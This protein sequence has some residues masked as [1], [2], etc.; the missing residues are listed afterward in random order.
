MDLYDRLNVPRSAGKA[1]I[2]AHY[3]REAKKH[4]PDM[5]PDDPD[6]ATTNMQEI[7]H[8]YAV[9]KDPE[10]RAQYDRTDES[11]TQASQNPAEAILAALMSMLTRKAI[12]E[13]FNIVAEARKKLQEAINA[14]TQA[15]PVCLNAISALEKI[16]AR[17][18]VTGDD[19][20][21]AMAAESHIAKAKHELEAKTASAK[22]SKDAL[23]MLEGYTDS[24]I[25]RAMAPEQVLREQMQGLMGLRGQNY[26]SD[27]FFF[28]KNQS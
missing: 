6:S 21:V 28:N 1:T 11:E 27:H 19:N 20:F 4:H 7:Q 25:E 15:I 14:D 13:E 22:A 24:F 18:S 17:V 12:D 3:L 8:A 9:L 26:R 10:A 23:A 2:R 5:H 16:V